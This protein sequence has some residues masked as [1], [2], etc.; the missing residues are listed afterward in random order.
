[1]TSHGGEFERIFAS[2]RSAG[3]SRRQALRALGAAGI[4]AAGLPF[5]AG[6]SLAETGQ[7]LGPGGIPLAR[8]DKPVTLPLHQD[9]IKSGLK[10]ETGGT[11]RLF[12]Y[13]D[14]LDKKAIDDFGKKYDVSVELTSFDSMDQA[15]TRLASHAV[16]PDVTNITPD[17]LAQAVAGK[18][19]RPI[20][21][22]YIP[23]LKKNIWPALQSPFYDVGSLYTVPYTTYA[24]GIG[25][26]ADKI[27]EDIAKLEN[28]WSIFWQ[29]QKYKGYVGVLDDSRE[30]LVLGMLYR[31]FYDINT[32]NP[33]AIEKALADMK[34]MIPICNPKINITDYQTL[35]TGVSW[36]HQSWSGSVLSAFLYNLPAGDDGSYLRYWS[37]PSGKGPVQNDCWAVL[38]TS[39]KPVLAH[40]FLDYLLDK[41]VAYHNFVDFNGYQPPQ[42]SIT[43]ESLIGDKVIPENLR[44]AIFT[45]D[46][47]GPNSLQEMTLTTKGQ[48]LW[49]KAFARFTSGT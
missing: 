49:Q 27:S 26:R 11:F 18:L 6:K 43:A 20:N 47:F 3:M 45:S 41:D 44:S 28:P 13:A 16:R 9:P 15:I 39:R 48:A 29:S 40:L 36:L 23:N 25:W 2:Q 8:P 31:H 35:P 5:F 38:A 22:D 46:A 17:R 32:E 19:L 37:P 7:L 14:Y 1:M 34:A 42:V 10:P 21:L 33:A 30:A 24:T 12:N 4:G